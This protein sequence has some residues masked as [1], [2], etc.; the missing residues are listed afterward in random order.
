MKIQVLFC[1]RCKENAD[2]SKVQI[3]SKYFQSIYLIKE[4]IHR[5]KIKHTNKKAINQ[6]KDE[7]QV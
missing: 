1:E 4:L 2:K 3:K 7:Q 5:E 6:I